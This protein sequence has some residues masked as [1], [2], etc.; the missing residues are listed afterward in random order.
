MLDPM[1]EQELEAF[2]KRGPRA[3]PYRPGRS[4]TLAR[5]GLVASSQVT[6]SQ[7]GLDMLRSG[8][9]AMDAAVA[10][11][12]VLAVMEP[13]M[14]GLGGDVFF[15][16]YENATG[17]VHGLNGS[18]R[19]PRNLTYENLIERTNGQIDAH[20]WDSVTVPGTV[21]GWAAGLE[22]FG[23]KSLADVLA[24]AIQLAEQGFPVSELI[25]RLWSLCARML[26]RDRFAREIYLPRDRAPRV[27]EIF[28]NP[29]LADSLRAVADK[30]PEAFY[31]GDIA[32][33]IVRYSSETGGHLSMEDFAG[34]RSTW[35]DP[36]H[37]EYR[38]YKILQIPPNGQGIAVLLMLNLLR[39]FPVSD[40][41]HQS[42]EYLHLLIEAKKLAYADL[43]HFVGDLEKLP[44][45]G[46]KLLAGLLSEVYAGERRKEIDPVRAKPAAVHGLPAGR[47]T[48]YLTA[49]DERGDAVSLINSIYHPFGSGIVGGRTGI[50]LQNRG[51]DFSLEPDHLNAY[52]PGKRPFHTIIPG[53]V[54]KDK[55]L[56]MSYGMMGGSVQPQ[57]HVQF[58]LNHLDFGLNIQE[59]IDVPRFNHNEG[60]FVQFEFGQPRQT[61]EALEK[62]GHRIVPG[63]MGLY[64]GM[65]ALMIDPATGTLFGAAD[66]RQD[67]AALGY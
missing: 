16:Y 59:A 62:M 33:E 8:G 24:P 44:D 7:I 3:N 37:T 13:M 1:V 54:L 49:I 25:A 39:G 53:M 12:A 26:T 6:A 30:G 11:A 56:Y 35:V 4:M 14:T 23:C 46:E 48:T 67:G 63:A 36:I 15:L 61:L 55:R 64:G 29:L 58:L 43:H 31:R 40:M 34:H 32:A 60:R 41:I 2:E 20:S 42:P 65:Q 50:V 17:Q 47:D 19:S 18:G 66:P 52:A 28:R 10:A 45:R 38:G 57:V 22:R 21:D 27:G 5:H 51:V 9:R